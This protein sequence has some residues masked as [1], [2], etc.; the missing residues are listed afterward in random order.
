MTEEQEKELKEIISAKE[1]EIEEAQ[2]DTVVEKEEKPEEDKDSETESLSPD[3]VKDIAL[4]YSKAKAWHL[5]GKG[6]AVDWENKHLRESVAARI[7]GRLASASNELDIVKAFEIGKV[8]QPVQDDSAIK[9]LAEAINKA[10]E[11]T[12]TKDITPV[13]N[14][15]MPTITMPPISM[16]AN[17]PETKQ[18]QVVFSPV[19]QPSEV[20]VKNNVPIDNKTINEITVQPAEVILPEMPKEAEITTMKDGTRRLKVK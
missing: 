18:A 13:Y 11:K 14:F 10:A 4:W 2:A 8:A 6:N 9:A 5:K 16:T 15:T 17:M 1:E 12:E 19:I 20:V 3:E 7:R